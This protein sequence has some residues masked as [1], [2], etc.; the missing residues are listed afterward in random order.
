MKKVFLLIA[1]V[2]TVFTSNNRNI[3]FSLKINSK[4]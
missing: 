3:L 2:A 4:K 1:L